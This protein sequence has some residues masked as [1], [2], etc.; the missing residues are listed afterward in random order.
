MLHKGLPTG[1]RPC[2]RLAFGRARLISVQD[3]SELIHVHP[4]AARRLPEPSATVVD[5]DND[6]E[7]GPAARRE[8][9]RRGSPSV[10]RDDLAAGT[11][12]SLLEQVKRFL[13][14]AWPSSVGPLAK[15][16]LFLTKLVVAVE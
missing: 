4:A 1:M 15:S 14:K 6:Q 12:G 5:S 10:C 13:F 8:V 3:T 11:L 2:H 9:K 7:P 16:G